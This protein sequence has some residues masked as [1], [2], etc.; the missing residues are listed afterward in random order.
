MACVPAGMR[1][2]VDYR[3]I[4][5]KVGRRISNRAAFSKYGNV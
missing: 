3:E 4:L 1:A 5:K 2:H